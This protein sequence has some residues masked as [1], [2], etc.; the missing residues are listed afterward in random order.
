ME[1]GTDVYLL[2]FTENFFFSFQPPEQQF[3]IPFC[4]FMWERQAL[5]TFRFTGER[6]RDG[7]T[8]VW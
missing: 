5:P 1:Y 8:S 7:F 6:H 2:F 3:N 4:L